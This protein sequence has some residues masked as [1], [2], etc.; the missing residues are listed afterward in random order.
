[1]MDRLLIIFLGLSFSMDIPA[2]D[3]NR[4]MDLLE[5][6]CAF[7]PRYPGSSGHLE[8][9]K[10]MEEHIRKEQIKEQIQKRKIKKY[11]K[12]QKKIKNKERYNNMNPN[13]FLYQ[14]NNININPIDR[15]KNSKNNNIRN[16]LRYKNF[17]S[18]EMDSIYNSSNYSTY[19]Y[20]FT[21][22]QV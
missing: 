11:L 15:E 3:A 12:M 22:D 20:D 8:M 17:N 14:D 19:S 7:G 13:D 6:Q 18:D 9:K 4:A 1:M 5:T 10:F 2:F 21:N 16:K